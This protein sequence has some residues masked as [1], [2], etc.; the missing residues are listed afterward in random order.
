MENFGVGV[1]LVHGD[2]RALRRED[3]EFD[4]VINFGT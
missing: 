1:E 3:G 4:V 2:I